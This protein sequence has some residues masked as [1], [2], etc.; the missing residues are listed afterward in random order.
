MPQSPANQR[1]VS[2]VRAHLRSL[3]GRHSGRECEAVVMTLA[4]RAVSLASPLEKAL[5]ETDHFPEWL[6]NDLVQAWLKGDFS[7]V[8]PAEEEAAPPAAE[9]VDAVPHA[10][11]HRL[12]GRAIDIYLCEHRERLKASLGP[13][14]SKE[15]EKALKK[16]GVQEFNE[17]TLADKQRWFDASAARV[18]KTDAKD[19]P[20]AGVEV[21]KGQLVHFGKVLLDLVSGEC[22][23]RA[24]KALRR[25]AKVIAAQAFAKKT[26]HSNSLRKRL[27]LGR[28]LATT[29]VAA[30]KKGRKMI[31]K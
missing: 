13:M 7:F 6:S 5:I 19:E 1:Q 17:L 27:G 28:K 31:G 30:K 21:T 2:K 25:V 3:L 10:A 29:G 12:K 22:G 16:A 26:V 11:R 9:A 14:D 20:A 23:D 15:R 8:P 18:A 24:D 4:R